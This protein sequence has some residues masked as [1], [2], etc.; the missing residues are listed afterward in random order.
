[1]RAMRLSDLTDSERLALAK[2]MD[3]KPAYLWQL[4]T[5]W[6]GKKPSLGFMQKMVQ[7]D[8][9]LTLGELAEEFSEPAE[10]KAA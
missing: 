9:R 1:M 6:R 8:S 4:A 3:I 5:R 7:A 2:S 10:Q